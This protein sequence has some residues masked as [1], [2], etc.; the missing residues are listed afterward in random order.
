MNLTAKVDGKDV[1]ITLTPGQL[2]EIAKQTQKTKPVTERISGWSDVF[3]ELGI[4]DP[5]PYKNAKTKFEKYMNACA[6]IPK[7]VE[8][9]N[10][11]T[12]LD[13]KNS[14]EYKYIPRKYWSG[15]SG[16]VVG[17]SN[18]PSIVS[19]SGAHFFKSNALAEDALSKFR[20]TYEDF[21]MID[22]KV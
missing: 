18:W 11:G 20:E 9:Y 13:W 8:V 1:V 22:E 15:G 19:S 12:I 7:L 14:N 3:D 21:W 5:A 10:E 4:E 16:W 2:K 17:V 6:R